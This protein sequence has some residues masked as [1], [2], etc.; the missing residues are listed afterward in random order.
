MNKDHRNEDYANN[1]QNPMHIEALYGL[2]MTR[3]YICP[4]A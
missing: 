3:L 4:A 2:I 1:Y